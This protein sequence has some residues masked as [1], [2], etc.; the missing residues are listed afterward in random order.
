MIN[1]VCNSPSWSSPSRESPAGAFEPWHSPEG[2]LRDDIL[3]RGTLRHACPQREIV[4]NDLSGMV[5]SLV[6]LFIVKLSG[7][8]ALSQSSPSWDAPTFILRHGVLPRAAPW[9]DLFHQISQPG[10]YHQRRTATGALRPGPY[11]RAVR[12][13]PHSQCRTTG[14]HGQG[15]TAQAIRPGSYCRGRTGRA[16]RTWPHGQG[17]TGRVVPAGP[18]D[19]ENL[20]VLLKHKRLRSCGLWLSDLVVSMIVRLSGKGSPSRPCPW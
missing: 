14:S 18:H 15:R 17:R 13:G 7:M 2:S 10:P 16:I 6:G 4:R 3:P 5:L 12:P 9:H 8:D 19:R 20:H 11:A 1:A